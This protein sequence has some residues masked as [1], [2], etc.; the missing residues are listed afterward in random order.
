MSRYLSSEYYIYMSKNMWIRGYFSHPKGA[1]E[2]KSFGDT[3]LD[4]TWKSSFYRTKNK[5][6]LHYIGRSVVVVGSNHFFFCKDR[7]KQIRCGQNLCLNVTLRY[8]GTN[9]VAWGG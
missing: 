9:H 3:D 1:H 7:T 4:N 6:R 2:R 5:P 8:T